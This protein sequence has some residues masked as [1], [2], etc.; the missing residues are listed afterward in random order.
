MIKEDSRRRL[1]A[2]LR[3]RNAHGHVTRA[4]Y[5]RILWENAADQDRDNR[6]VRACAV[7][8]YMDM[9]QEPFYARMPE[10]TWSTLIKHQP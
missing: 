4:I 6:F 7:E 1:C 2:S 3:S 8:M 10:A 5:A 9:S